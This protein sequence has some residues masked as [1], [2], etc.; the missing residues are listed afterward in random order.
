V[1]S[2]ANLS[3]VSGLRGDPFSVER[4]H[5]LLQA[6]P[7]NCDDPSGVFATQLRETLGYPARLKCD[8][9]IIALRRQ[10]SS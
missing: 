9:T 4:A 5:E 1:L 7:E 3:D 2:G 10:L 8:L 6:L